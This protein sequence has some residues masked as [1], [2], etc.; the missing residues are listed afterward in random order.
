MSGSNLFTEMMLGAD[1]IALVSRYFLRNCVSVKN[2]AEMATSNIL[3]KQ[4]LL[5]LSSELC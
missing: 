2:G 4:F 3:Q 1:I 5:C